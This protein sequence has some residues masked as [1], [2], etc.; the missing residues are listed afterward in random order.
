VNVA[1]NHP[2]LTWTL[3]TVKIYHIMTLNKVTKTP[4]ILRYSEHWQQLSGVTMDMLATVKIYH[5]MTLTKG[6]WI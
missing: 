2:E 1:N 5:V 4:H 3:A 6:I